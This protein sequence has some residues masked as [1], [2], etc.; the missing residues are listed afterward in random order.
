MKQCLIC[1]K[2]PVWAGKYK[3]LMSRYNPLPQ[4]KKYPNLQWLK[5]PLDIKK[6]PFEKF[7]GKK[8]L[9]CTKCLK[10]LFS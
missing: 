5:I 10:T 9:A 1:G 7:A 8:I 4:R 3:K 6:K 2:K